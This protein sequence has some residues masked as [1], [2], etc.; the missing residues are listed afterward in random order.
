VSIPFAP[1]L[2]PVTAG[3]GAALL[4]AIAAR[5]GGHPLAEPADLFRAAPPRRTTQS[6]RVALL[7]ALAALFVIDVAIRRLRRPT[8]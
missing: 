5:T 8:G 7:L 1:E 4:A 3:T 2:R 6:L